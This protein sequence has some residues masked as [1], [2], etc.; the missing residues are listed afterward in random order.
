MVSKH[1]FVCLKLNGASLAMPLSWVWYSEMNQMHKYIII[2]YV[3][4]HRNVENGHY[5]CS[6]VWCRNYCVWVYL[7]VYDA[8]LMQKH[9]CWC[10]LG[11]VEARTCFVKLARALDLKHEVSS[12]HILHNKEQPV[13]KTDRERICC[14][15]LIRAWCKIIYSFAIL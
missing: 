6:C 10:H 12:V 13:L 4:V 15:F 8:M 11:C 1:Y 2:I 14:F 7:P 9:K 3:K 5:F